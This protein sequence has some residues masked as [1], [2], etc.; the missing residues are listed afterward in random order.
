MLVKQMIRIL[1]GAFKSTTTK[2]WLLILYNKSITSSDIRR[3]AVSTYTISNKTWNI[4]TNH[5]NP[6]N[7]FLVWKDQQSSFLVES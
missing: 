7:R 4:C 2:A 1:S 5:R 3:K 6:F